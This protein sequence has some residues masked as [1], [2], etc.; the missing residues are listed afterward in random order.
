[1]T[2]QAAV[3]RVLLPFVVV[4]RRQPVGQS[5]RAAWH[6]SIDAI[7]GFLLITAALHTLR[8]VTSA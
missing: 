5:S 4:H 2:A 7:D 1:M 3:E 8:G 6:S